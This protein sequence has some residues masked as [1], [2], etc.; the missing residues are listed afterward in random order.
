MLCGTSTAGGLQVSIERDR[1]RIVREGGVVKFVDQ[2]E[3]ISFSARRALETDQEVLYV[4]ERAVFRLQDRGLQLI[5][6]AS[7]IEVQSQVLALMNFRPIVGE[8]KSMPKQAF[9]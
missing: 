5:E 7:G 2:V 8:V 6:V 9:R 4:T 3:Q 1:L